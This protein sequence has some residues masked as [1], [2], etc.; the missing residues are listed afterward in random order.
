[1]VFAVKAR[2]SSISETRFL[3]LKH[4]NEGKSDYLASVESP[5]SSVQKAQFIPT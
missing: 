1:M 5:V 2:L 3:M 4:H